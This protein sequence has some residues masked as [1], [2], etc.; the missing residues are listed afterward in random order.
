MVPCL[1]SKHAVNNRH[2]QPHLDTV[3]EVLKN[4]FDVMKEF[5]EVVKGLLKKMKQSS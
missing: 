1:I 3:C 4:G 2:C 5:E